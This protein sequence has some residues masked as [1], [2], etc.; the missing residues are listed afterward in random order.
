M[1]LLVP[2]IFEAELLLG[3][4]AVAPLREGLPATVTIGP[5]RCVIALCGFGLAAAG[6][7]AA[8]WMTRLRGEQPNARLDALLVGLAGS[9]DTRR[10]PVG[11]V[12]VASAAA[13][14]GIGIGEGADYRA[15]QA[16]GWLQVP[17][18]PGRPPV[19][20]RIEL[21][22]PTWLPVAGLTRGA[23]LSVAAASATPAMAA[24]RAE[25][26]P[27]ALAEDMESYAVAI[28]AGLA[29]VRLVVVRAISNRAGKREG[30]CTAEAIAAARGTLESILAG[31]TP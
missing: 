19:G 12:V 10:A 22:D 16:A 29:R 24:R 23:V 28:A 9:Y 11:S 17:P 18:M 14:D 15:S 4:E 2:T 20:D 27:D 30:W 21:A 13:C 5:R 3:A 8:H 26:H 7:C 25:A 6:A 31:G 1:L